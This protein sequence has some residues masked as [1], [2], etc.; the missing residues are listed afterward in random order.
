MT[1]PLVL[2]AIRIVDPDRGIDTTGTLLVIDGKIAAAGAEALNQGC[3]EGAEVVDGRRLTALPGLIDAR[4]FIGEP[5]GEHR[6]TIRSASRAAA[7]GGVTSILT[8]PDTDPVVDHVALAEFV[9]R[10]ARETADINVFPAAALTRGL[11]GE[12]MT[13]IGLLGAAGVRAFTE[14]RKTIANPALLRRIMT[15]ARD[16]DAL[17]MHETQDADLTGTGVMTE[18]LLASWLGLP[19]VPREAEVIPLERDLRL[20]ELTGCRYHAAKI[21]VASSADAVRRAKSRGLSVTAG[22]SINHLALNENDIGEYRTYFRLSPPLRS[23]DDR[24]SMVEAVADGTI[25]IIVSSHDPHDEDGKRHPFAEAE[26]GAIGLETL[27]AAALRLHHDGSLPLLRVV[28]TLTAAPAKLLKLDRGTLRPGRPADI[29][30]VDLDTPFIYGKADIRSL[31][32]NTAF[33]NARFQGRVLRTI[34]AGRTVFDA[35]DGG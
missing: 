14:G 2:E 13:E 22:V 19:G 33:E 30:I 1:R 29:A 9:M 18:G 21:S 16:F 17:V 11:L 26:V 27:L 5:G 3:P 20:A 12:E 8:M 4:V 35:T 32:K 25:D 28:E 34:V 24:K 23:E 10:T 6:E 15:Y 7:A 31:S